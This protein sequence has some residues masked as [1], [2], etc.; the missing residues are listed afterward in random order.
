MLLGILAVL[1]AGAVAAVILVVVNRPGSSDAAGPVRQD[2]PGPVLLVPG[3]GGSTSALDVLAA[4]LRSAGR[5]ATVVRLPGDGTGALRDQAERSE[6][7]T[8]ELQS[9]RDLVCRLLLEKKKS[10][11]QGRI[12]YSSM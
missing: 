3:Y 10:K 6:E 4:R 1:V 2:D 7:H 8:S 12:S 9:R 5:Q 11:K